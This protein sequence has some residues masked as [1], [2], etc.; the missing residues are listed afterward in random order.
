MHNELSPAKTRSS[1]GQAW[2]AGA[3]LFV[4]LSA[5]LCLSTFFHPPPALAQTRVY[6]LTPTNTM[7][8]GDYFVVDIA[9]PSSSTGFRTMRLPW[10]TLW[11]LVD[12]NVSQVLTNYGF[13]GTNFLIEP[14]VSNYFFTNAF[15]DTY[16]SNYFRT[17]TFWTNAYHTNVT[18]TNYYEGDTY[19][20]DYFTTNIYI[21]NEYVSNY[22]ATNTT[23]YQWYITSNYFTTVTNVRQ[24]ITQG[25]MPTTNRWNGPTNTL[26][27]RF[28]HQAYA[29]YTP[30]YVSGVVRQVSAD[31]ARQDQE[32]Y[33]SLFN[34]ADTNWQL[35]LPEGM[36][37]DEGMSGYTC[38]A[39]QA[40]TLH[41]RWTPN[42]S[43][44]GWTNCEAFPHWY[45]RLKVSNL[46]N[47]LLWSTNAWVKNL[48]NNEAIISNA[49]V[50]HLDSLKGEIQLLSPFRCDGAGAIIYSND[51]TKS[52][53]AQAEFSATAAKTANWADYYL[54]VPFDFDSS[55]DL[56]ATLK[57]QLKAADTGKHRYTLQLSSVADSAAYIGSLGSEI[58]LDF[59]G[60]ANGDTGD[61]ESTSTVTLTG[62][63]SAMTA[64]QLLVI[65][66]S[67]SGDDGT[68]D[69]S[70]VNSYSGPLTILYG[71]KQ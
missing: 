23:F 32:T 41:V 55:I 43:S 49:H 59:A 54:N 60:D 56:T 12:S 58:N 53:Y 68:Y 16:L 67:R 6:Q 29:S 27:L 33:L 15:F 63:K 25:L 51:N 44:G 13:I 31:D 57:F 2:I 38:E 35:T 28:W 40:L 62:W 9:D 8:A 52:Y 37:S 22:Y 42:F 48:T 10:T 24:F 70:T 36:I 65:R 7:K 21:N 5:V 4:I 69:T 61:V 17:N 14:V 1:S 46:T 39:G 34:L 47:N 20:S 50:I 30:C 3:V 64:G 71:M 66:L 19:V 11:S 26:Q 45:Y 18:I